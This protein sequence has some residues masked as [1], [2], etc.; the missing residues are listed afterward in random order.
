MA[1]VVR[2][3]FLAFY[4]DKGCPSWRGMFCKKVARELATS[5][6]RGTELLNY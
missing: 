1:G 2:R 4:F 3:Y 6:R 5:F